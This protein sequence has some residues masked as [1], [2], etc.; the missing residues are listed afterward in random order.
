MVPLK[1]GTYNKENSDFTSLGNIIH[2]KENINWPFTFTTNYPHIDI[3]LDQLSKSN[4]YIDI[5]EREKVI[6]H[7][8]FDIV[9]QID[10]VVDTISYY[11]LDFPKE[12]KEHCD[13]F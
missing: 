12:E 1:Y 2:Y 3:Y 6:I 13:I 8:S 7:T 5:V 9:E 10:L 11:S 4:D